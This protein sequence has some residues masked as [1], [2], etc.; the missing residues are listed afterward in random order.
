[1][2]AANYWTKFGVSDGEVG[3]GTG[4]DEGFCSSVEGAT[5]STG[6]TSW[7]YWEVD[8]QPKSTY[9]GPMAPAMY[10]AEDS[11]SER[12]GPWA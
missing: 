10:V 1:M 3:E 2:L 5:E 7:S 11:I 4:G 9:R 8:H 6:Q 12:R